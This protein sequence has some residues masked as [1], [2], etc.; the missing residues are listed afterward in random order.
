MTNMLEFTD[1]L[2]YVMDDKGEP[3][4]KWADIAPLLGYCT[5]SA[6]LYGKTSFK[7]QKMLSYEQ[8]QGTDFSL[9]WT[10][11]YHGMLLFVNTYGLWE[12]VLKSDSPYGHALREHITQ[13]YMPRLT[14]KFLEQIIVK[15]NY[16][17]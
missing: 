7:N 3:W 5:T 6:V 15:D 17:E 4:F 2:N 1:K 12:L 10:G 13:D 16:E 8:A 11:K 9:F 14:N